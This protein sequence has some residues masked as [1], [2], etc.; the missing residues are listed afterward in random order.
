MSFD[1]FEPTDTKQFTWQASVAPDAAPVFKVYSQLT[2]TTVASIT[3][4]ASD[5]THYY[6]LYTFP[7]SDNVYYRGEWFALKTVGGSAYQLVTRFVFHV[8]Q[9]VTP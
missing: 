7:S 9:T 2:G 4:T 3:S 5:T 8:V 1:T 6:A